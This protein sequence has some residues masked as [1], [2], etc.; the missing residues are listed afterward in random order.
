VNRQIEPL[1]RIFTF[2]ID[3]GFANSNLCRRVKKFRVRGGR[4]RPLLPDEE[5]RLMSYVDIKK[6][7]RSTCDDAKIRDLRFHD[8]R[9][10]FGTRLAD[11]GASTRTIMD[12]M[13]HSQNGNK[14]PLHSRNRPW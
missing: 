11:S 4:N 14:P 9:H 8:L 12:L 6:G 13:G 1:S 10:T 3:M 5:A 2:A 7:F